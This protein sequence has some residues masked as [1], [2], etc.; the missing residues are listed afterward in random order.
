MEAEYVACYEAIQEVVWLRNLISCFLV[1]KSISKLLTIYCDNTVAINFSQN[2]E[3]STCM[4]HFDVKYQ[5]VIEKIRK[6][7]TYIE[8][9]S[10]NC[11]PINP[12]TKGLTIGIYHDH[13]TSIGSAKSFVT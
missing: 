8:H 3:N 1:V 13:V 7:V 9:I 2:N 6:H 12:L 10:M 4:K 5:F 11:M